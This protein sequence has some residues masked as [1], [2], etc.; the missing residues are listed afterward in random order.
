[1]RVKKNMTYVRFNTIVKNYD[2]GPVYTII[3]I[4][5]IGPVLHYS[6]K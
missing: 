4:Y 2:I 3:K 6:K 5:D 1:M